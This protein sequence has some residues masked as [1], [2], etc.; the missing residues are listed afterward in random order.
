MPTNTTEARRSLRGDAERQ[1]LAISKRYNTE[2]LDVVR[3]VRAR[4]PAPDTCPH[5]AIQ[6]MEALERDVDAIGA[7]CREMQEKLEDA[8]AATHLLHTQAS[9]LRGERYAAVALPTCLQS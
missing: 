7:A 8:H 5:V 1:S 9:L 2:A 6:S 3:E 4:G